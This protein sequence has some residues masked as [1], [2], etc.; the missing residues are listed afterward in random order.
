[1]TT[2][3]TGN[4][5]ACLIKD[6]LFV[7][8]VRAFYLYKFAPGFAFCLNHIILLRKFELAQSESFSQMCF[9]AGC[10][11]VSY[12]DLLSR[13]VASGNLGELTHVPDTA[14]ACFLPVDP[15][16]AGGFPLLD[17]LNFVQLVTATKRAVC[18]EF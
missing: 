8:A 5:A 2:D 4:I 9:L 7:F 12:I 11:S 15:V 18:L 6:K 10:A 16:Q 17:F 13:L 1:M 14:T 3:D